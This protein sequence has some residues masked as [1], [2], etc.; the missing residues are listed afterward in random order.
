MGM[1][2]AE[3]SLAKAAGKRSV[4]AGDVLTVR[5]DLAIR[6]D[7]PQ[8][9]ERQIK[10]LQEIGLEKVKYPEQIVYFIDHC[11]PPMLP[12]EADLH[13]L[14]R[15]WTKA[16][17]IRLFEG[18]IGH[19]LSAE[20]GLARPG[21]LIVHS[22]A[23]VALLGAFGSLGIAVMHDLLSVFALG[24]T[25]LEVPECI[26]INLIGSLPEGV[27]SRDLVLAITAHFGA[28]GALNKVI[29]YSGPGLS[30]ISIDGRMPLCGLVTFMGAVSGI[31]R[32]DEAVLDYLAPRTNDKVELITSDP[33]ANYDTKMEL[34]LSQVQP[35][36]AVPHSPANA[37]PIDQVTGTVVNQ[38]YIGSCASGRLEDLR[39]AAKILEGRHLAP[40]FRLNVVPS[41]NDIFRAALRE[42]S[43]EKLVNSGAF[44][45]SPTC[46][47]CW[48]RT[49]N[50]AEGDIAVSTGTLNVKGRMGNANGSIYLGSAATVAVAALT[51]KLADPRHYLS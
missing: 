1:T 51:G 26:L 11:L 36:V 19:Q 39:I 50:L 21:R 32:P 23:H 47:Y 8:S 22:E 20:L 40:G 27:M 2:L 33:D 15:E 3:K 5:P 49:Q 41:S 18:G 48:G 45:S 38:G 31:A 37:I 24:E 30:S 14:T 7:F 25:W 43:I 35:M 9:S 42:G 4:S 12:E 17:G 6:Y 29:E 16:Q 10:M 28:R 44:V 13:K 46:D 34:N